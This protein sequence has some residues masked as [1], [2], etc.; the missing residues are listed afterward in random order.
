M[1]KENKGVAG[2]PLDWPV[3]RK[4]TAPELRERAAYRKG[5]KGNTPLTIAEALGRVTRELSLLGAS[6]V[7]ISSNLAARN[8]AMPYSRQPE[9]EDPGVAVY[10]TLVGEQ[11]CLWSDGWDRVADNIAAVAKWVGGQR[12]QLRCKVGDVE[13]AFAGFRALPPSGP[14]PLEVRPLSVDHAA[15]IICRRCS[16]VSVEEAVDDADKAAEAYRRSA[17]V[18]HPDRGGEPA[19]FQAL[20]AAKRI[21]DAHHGRSA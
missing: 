6:E 5:R 14:P 16:S 12:D 8:K 10:F 9:P 7:I 17:M 2:Y 20:Q 11:R 15:M 19:E 18:L 4:R 21:M 1:S 13:S 3:G